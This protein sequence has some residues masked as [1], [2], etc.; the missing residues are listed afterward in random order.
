MH[1]TSYYNF[2]YVLNISEHISEIATIISIFQYNFNANLKHFFLNL[3]I[4]SG[5]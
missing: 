3:F 4:Q 5:M 1:N 2:G